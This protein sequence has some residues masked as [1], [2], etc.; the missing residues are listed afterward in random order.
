MSIMTLLPKFDWDNSKHN[1]AQ[2]PIAIFYKKHGEKHYSKMK[3][4][5][6]YN[7]WLEYT[8]H[9]H[10]FLTVRFHDKH[11]STKIIFNKLDLFEMLLLC[12][13]IKPITKRKSRILLRHGLGN[14]PDTSEMY[15]FDMVKS[16]YDEALWKLKHV[17]EFA[18]GN[19]KELAEKQF[20]KLM[21]K[22]WIMDLLDEIDY[23]NS[24]EVDDKKV[25][26]KTIK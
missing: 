24:F 14:I 16:Q 2:S 19:K 12:L 3:G 8:K 13:R 11:G 4:L 6:K 15:S 1:I 18:E 9:N 22:E 20:D 5:K 26:I 25:K 17:I 23:A 10:L 7:L 21:K